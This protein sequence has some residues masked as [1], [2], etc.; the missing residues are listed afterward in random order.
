MLLDSVI[1]ERSS[2]AC[3]LKG[4]KSE[5]RLENNASLVI[6]VKQPR[7]GNEVKNLLMWTWP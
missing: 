5:K 6:V 2:W 4:E 7:S 1:S 3:V